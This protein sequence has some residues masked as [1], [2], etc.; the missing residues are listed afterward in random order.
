MQ[1]ASEIGKEWY[2]QAA[3]YAAYVIGKTGDEV[4]GIAV[5]ESGKATDAE[6]LAGVT[7]SIGSF[8]EVVAKAVTNAK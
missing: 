8:N 7:V 5:D 2:E 6:L 1:K 4:S 3:S